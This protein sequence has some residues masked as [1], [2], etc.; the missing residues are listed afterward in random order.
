MA[1]KKDKSPADTRKP[2]HSND[3]N[4]ANKGGKAG[5][6]SASTVRGGGGGGGGGGAQR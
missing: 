4:R 3:K 5:L 6:R 2:K 1:K